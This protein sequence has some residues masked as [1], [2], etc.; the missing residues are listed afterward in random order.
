M[1][2][3]ISHK[4]TRNYLQQIKGLVSA[5]ELQ[6]ETAQDVAEIFTPLSERKFCIFR[7]DDPPSRN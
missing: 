4:R 5:A 6:V 7:F 1:I 3:N 2:V